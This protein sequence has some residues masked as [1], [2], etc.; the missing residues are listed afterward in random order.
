MVLFRP[1][2]ISEMALITLYTLKL[3]PH[4]NKAAIGSL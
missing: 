2:Q 4:L 3:N 1:Q